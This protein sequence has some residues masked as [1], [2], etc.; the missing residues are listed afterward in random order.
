MDALTASSVDSL[1]DRIRHMASRPVPEFNRFEALDLL[2][3]LKNS[4]QDVKHEK[5]GY[6][7]FAF[8]TLRGEINEPNDQFCNF[9]LLLLEDKDQE[10]VL[11]VVAEV[12]KNNRR[13]EVRQN[14]GA[15]RKARA[16]PYSGIR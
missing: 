11:D 8:E 3:A 13:R 14:P 4:A 15:E 1:L 10:E 2:E 6:Y 16:A 9:L 7:K 12:G 5:E